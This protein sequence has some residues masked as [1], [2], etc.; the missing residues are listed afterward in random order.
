MIVDSMTIEEI[1]KELYSDF[2]NIFPTLQYRAEKFRSL[3]LKT[4]RFP[5]R[6]SYECKSLVR[7]NRFFVIFTAMKRSHHKDPLQGYYCIYDRPEGL[8]C[9]VM[10]PSENRWEKG[11]IC[12]YPPHFFARYRERLGID[13]SISRVD[14]IHHF[15]KHQW[16][17]AL[18]MFKEM[19][20]EEVARKFGEDAVPAEGTIKPYKGDVKWDEMLDEEDINMVMRDARG[21]I[22]GAR[23]ENTIICKTF[24]T[25]DMVFQDQFPLFRSVNYLFYKQ[26]YDQF[27][28]EGHMAILQYEDMPLLPFGQFTEE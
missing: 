13:E 7:R 26:L 19:D 28:K 18:M 27:G 1:Y 25:D 5:L 8:Y 9:A 6:Q 12:V 16:T 20:N 17:I 23:H 15:M 3:C 11:L 24:I 21:F 4:H 22:L 10:H 2:K 14:L